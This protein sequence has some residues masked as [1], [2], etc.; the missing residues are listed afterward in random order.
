[1]HASFMCQL[2]QIPTVD[3]KNSVTRLNVRIL[4]FSTLDTVKLK[5]YASILPK[6]NPIQTTFL[7]I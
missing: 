5:I 4:N 7:N 3:A 2:Y 1:M 6:L